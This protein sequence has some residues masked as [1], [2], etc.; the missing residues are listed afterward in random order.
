MNGI[1]HIDCR[2]SAFVSVWVAASLPGLC[3]FVLNRRIDRADETGWPEENFQRRVFG[4][5]GGI[6]VAR[7]LDHA[8][9][10]IWRIS[11]T[12]K[13]G[14]YRSDRTYYPRADFTA[15]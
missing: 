2:R 10:D 8:P 6:Q 14:K 5:V 13:I 4:R 12:M 15:G 1:T 3:S 11:C 7:R 9:R